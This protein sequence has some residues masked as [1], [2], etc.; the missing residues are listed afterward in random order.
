MQSAEADCSG[1]NWAEQPP[2]PK[3]NKQENTRNQITDI[4]EILFEDYANGGH[5]K[6]R[7]IKFPTVNNNNRA[8]ARISE[9][10]ATTAS[11][12]MGL[13]NDVS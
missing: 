12:N 8:D 5:S 1:N 2:P 7:S 11:L 6:H 10:G 9:V 3:Q 13:L 4:H